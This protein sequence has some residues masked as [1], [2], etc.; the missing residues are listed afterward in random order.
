M[1]KLRVDEITELMSYAIKTHS[2]DF[3]ERISSLEGQVR[4]QAGTIAELNSI[5]TARDLEIAS[6]KRELNNG[7]Q[8]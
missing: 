3:R 8:S 1:A 7:N 5:I 4:R 6:L 2:S